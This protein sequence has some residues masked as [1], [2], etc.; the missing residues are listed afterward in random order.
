MSVV[1]RLTVAAFCLCLL[2]P[3]ARAQQE[4]KE[5]R[6]PQETAMQ[7][8]YQAAQAAAKS[9]PVEI[10]LKDQAVLK[11]PAGFAYI[12]VEQA[13]A[14]M[15]AMGN[16]VGPN[17]LGMVVGENLSGFVSINYNPAG[18]IKDDDAKDWKADEMLDNLKKGTEEVNEDR[19]QRGITEFEVTGWIEK[20]T[21][22]AG[23]HRLVWSAA[24]RDKGAPANATQGVNYNTY[25]L[26]REGYMSL[27]LVTDAD[28]V[29]REKPLARTLLA[30]V[31]FDSGKRYADF[32]SGTDKV[33]EFG[34]AA[35]IGGVAVKKLGLLAALGVFILKAWKL[36][37]VAL[38]G[39]GAAAR[40]FFGGRPKAEAPQENKDEG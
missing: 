23:S 6:S 25:L 2:A 34:L 29:E 39:I 12:P 27:N 11:L 28:S 31:E 14:V 24:L 3:L 18:Y 16:Q 9:G 13:G 1:R 37:A 26:G 38:V 33:A 22:D 40:K 15:R 19:R 10:P 4:A 20:P 7:Q 21:Y 32:N 36:T 5:T 8:A 17:Y 30:A 35:L